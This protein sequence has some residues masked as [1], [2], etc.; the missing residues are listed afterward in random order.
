MALFISCST[1]SKTEVDLLIKNA[2]IYKVDDEFATASAMAIKDGKIVAIGHGEDVINK[3]T[4][5]QVYDAEGKTIIPGF[6]DAHAHLYSH[7]LKKFNVNLV[8]S[9]TVNEVLQRILDFHKENPTN[10][11]RGYGWDQN[12]WNNKN[13]PTKELLDS[14][15]P[16]IPVVLS[17]I[18]GHDLWVNSNAL[19]LAEINSS[20]KMSGG[21]VILSDGEPTGI[22]IDAPMQLVYDA[23]PKP[24]RRTEIRALL[25]AEK[26]VFSYGLTTVVDA[27]LDRGIVE[28]IDSLHRTGDLKLK[29]YAMLNN[30]P[31]NRKHFLEVGVSQTQRLNIRSFKVF[32]D[33]ALGSRGALMK[34]EYSDMPGH[35]GFLVTPLDSLEYLANLLATTDFQMNAHAIGDSANCSLLRIYNS[36]LKDLEDKRWRIEHAQVISPG[37]FDY[38]SDNIIPS[39]QPTHA[40]SDMYW[41]ENRIGTERMKGAYAYQT[42][43]SKSGRIAL[44]TDFPVEAINPMYT[45]YSAVVRKDLHQYPADGFYK[46][47]ALSREQALRGMTIWAAYANFEE[48]EKGSL[49]V[50]KWADFIILDKDLM[51]VDDDQLPMIKVLKT[52]VNGEKVF[53]RK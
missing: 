29:V 23:F 22:L 39:V 43:L 2:V 30:T 41:A 53:D 17:R 47:E 16:N 25:E 8:G 12:K 33:G 26:E 13:F 44:G 6:I 24:D 10:Y 27:G 32:T 4:S 34:K 42:L 11:I 7:G 3:Y 37:D 38:F 5:K 45:F 48:E 14:F 51:K 50:G 52:Y 36:A 40:T 46:E 20:T 9:E 18:D 15:F 49:E 1:P 31:E 21:E 19:D 28:L 35:Y